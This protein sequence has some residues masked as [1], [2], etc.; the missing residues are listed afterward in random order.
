MR[1]L[2][3][4]DLADQIDDALLDWLR[5]PKRRAPRGGAWRASCPPSAWRVGGVFRQPIHGLTKNKPTS[6][7]ASLRA[8][9][10][11]LHRPL[12]APTSRRASCAA[13]GA[14]RRSL[15]FRATTFLCTSTCLTAV[16]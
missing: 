6:V 2:G 4:H 10:P 9:P 13:T 12:G 14:L 5:Q 1:A 3:R 15:V 7:S 16:R 11:T 8:F